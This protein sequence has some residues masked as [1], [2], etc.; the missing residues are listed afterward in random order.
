[1]KNIKKA[2][3]I[4]GKCGGKKTSLTKK[5][6]CRENGKKGGRPKKNNNQEGL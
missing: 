2:A 6:A 5:R 4:L 1:M 3:S